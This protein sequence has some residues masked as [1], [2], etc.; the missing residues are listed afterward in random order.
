MNTFPD[1]TKIELNTTP[2]PVTFAQWQARFD[3]HRFLLP[4]YKA[5]HLMK[6]RADYVDGGR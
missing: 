3:G 4:P 6:S 2:A 1:F 5:Q